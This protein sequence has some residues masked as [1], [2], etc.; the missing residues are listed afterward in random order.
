MT[1]EEAVAQAKRKCLILKE[2]LTD[3]DIKSFLS[4]SL[5]ETEEYTE[6]VINI[7]IVEM[8][9]AILPVAPISYS[10]GNISISRTDIEKVLK[11]FQNKQIGSINLRR[12]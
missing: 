10:R 8:L 12:G 7:A 1:E 4:E 3:E 6:Q 2:F 11:E 9:K 5:N